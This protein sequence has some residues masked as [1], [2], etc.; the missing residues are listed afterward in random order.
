MPA[1]PGCP[2]RCFLRL[3]PGWGWT[4]ASLGSCSV[5]RPSP[6]QPSQKFRELRSGVAFQEIALCFN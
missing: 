6:P 5:R 1:V 4:L 3:G 2:H